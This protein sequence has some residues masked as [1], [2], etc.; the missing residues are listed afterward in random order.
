M[1]NDAD[2][3]RRHDALV[4]SLGPGP[5]EILMELLPPAGWT[6]LATR[7]DL[8]MLKTDLD[9][10]RTELRIEIQ[11]LRTEM[12][13]EMAGLR[14]EVDELRGEVRSLLPKFILANIG[15]M[16]GMA[17]LVVGSAAVL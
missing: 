10:V 17:G 14:S 9:I 5:S 6:G 11:D 7:T 12:K 16:I 13:A 4:E 1:I 8:N 2:R 15:T 3:R